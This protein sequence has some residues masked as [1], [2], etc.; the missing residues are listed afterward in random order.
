MKGLNQI[1]HD[2]LLKFVSEKKLTKIKT[3]EM[4]KYLFV[5][6]KDEEISAK[7]NDYFLKYYDFCFDIINKNMI[8]DL[9]KFEY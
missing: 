6:K 9:D 4:T 2:L 7:L 3:N 8:K 5:S 1:F